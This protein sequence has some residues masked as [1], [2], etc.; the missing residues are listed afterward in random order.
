MVTNT[1]YEAMDKIMG[2]R[3]KQA[4]DR[5][6]Y[7]K[8]IEV[9]KRLG[10]SAGKSHGANHNYKDNEIAIWWD[11]YGNN[12]DIILVTLDTL[13][14]QASDSS[15]F[16]VHLNSIT[17]YRPDVSDWEARLDK[18]YEGLEPQM[19]SEDSKEREKKRLEFFKAWGV[20]PDP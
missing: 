7:H 9:T 8:A 15:V 5:R 20:W 6:I 18:L 11:D 2:Q 10:T 12:M 17:G 16:K 1:E 19:K 3:R 4:E 13:D 14:D